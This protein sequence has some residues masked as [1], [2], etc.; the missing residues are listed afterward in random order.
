MTPTGTMTQ[1]NTPT[2]DPIEPS[3]TV[4]PDGA[5]WFVESD[6]DQ[7]GR[8]TTSGQ[9]SEFALPETSATGIDEYGPGDH[10]VEI[11][12]G[13]DGRLWV[14]DNGAN[15]GIIAA[16]PEQPLSPAPFPTLVSSGL[17]ASGIVSAFHDP[18]PLAAAGDYTTA[19]NWGDGTS[20]A[21]TVAATTGGDFNVSASHTYAGAGTYSIS[22]VITDIDTSHDLGGATL[23][24]STSYT[25]TSG[26]GGLAGDIFTGPGSSSQPVPVTIPVISRYLL[27]VQDLPHRRDVHRMPH[28]KPATTPLGSDAAHSRAV[29]QGSD[30]SLTAHDAVVLKK[31]TSGPSPRPPAHSRHAS[32]TKAVAEKLDRR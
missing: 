26:G 29:A 14:L 23:T 12:T 20:S 1:F 25:A 2:T 8:I 4:G 17:N 11:A 28:V 18:D 6:A 24:T 19:I 7:I 31:A 5:L 27:P 21:G 13:S 22:V 15:G 3:I 9:I 10:P 16:T 30:K 32:Q